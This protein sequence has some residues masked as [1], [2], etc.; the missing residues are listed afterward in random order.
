MR[1]NL[2][3]IKQ[4]PSEFFRPLRLHNLH[5]QLPNRILPPCNSIPQIQ[6]ME[7]GIH[8]GHPG[9]FLSGEIFSVELRPEME[10]AVPE[11]AIGGYELEGVYAEASDGSNG[12]WN[13]SR[14]EEMKQCVDAFGL[15]GVEV[16][17]LWY[18]RR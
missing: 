6:V 15:V 7:V 5:I 1:P 13:A 10:L 2:C 16:P 4:S 17:E 14:A 9:S 11:G 18:P 12:A 8:S 3:N